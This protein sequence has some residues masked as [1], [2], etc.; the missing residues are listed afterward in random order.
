MHFEN[1]I[2]HKI[3]VTYVIAKVSSCSKISK[4]IQLETV[5]LLHA[6]P[7]STAAC[8][9]QTVF[10]LENK[11]RYNESSTFLRQRRHPHRRHPRTDRRPRHC[12][13]QCR[14]VRHLRY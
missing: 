14:L 1:E 13:H 9:I 4:Q 5:K 2:E 3:L 7:I 10:L 12:R 11:E 6:I 8:Q